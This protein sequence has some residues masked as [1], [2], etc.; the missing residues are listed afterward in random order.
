LLALGTGA[1]SAIYP[2]IDAA[3]LRPCHQSWESRGRPCDEVFCPLG[4]ENQLF[5]QIDFILATTKN[6]IGQPLQ[7]GLT[8]FSYLVLQAG[9]LNR[10]AVT[11]LAATSPHR[12]P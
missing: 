11:K 3:F 5:F 1:N 2:V 4:L 10:V 7:A 12:A 8:H 9:E 6:R